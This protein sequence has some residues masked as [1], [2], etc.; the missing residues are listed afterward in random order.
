MVNLDYQLNVIDNHHGN[1]CLHMSVR[2]CLD[3][4]K[5]RTHMVHVTRLFY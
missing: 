2:D 3:S 4:T 5:L 1:K